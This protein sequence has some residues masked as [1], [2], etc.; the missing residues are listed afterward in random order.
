[1]LLPMYVQSMKY[2]VITKSFPII[3]I[4]KYKHLL[5]YGYKTLCYFKTNTFL[6][7]TKIIIHYIHVAL[8]SFLMNTFFTQSKVLTHCIHISFCAQSPQTS[9]RHFMGIIFYSLYISSLSFW[10]GNFFFVMIY[11]HSCLLYTSRCV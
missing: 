3:A 4:S 5:K 9:Y 10:D 11:I 8:C 2:G 6:T 7:K 1:M